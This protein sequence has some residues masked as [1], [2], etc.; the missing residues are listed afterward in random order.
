DGLAAVAH[1]GPQGAQVMHAGEEDGAEGDP[2]E[3]GQPA[4]DHRDRGA[5][6]RG[7]AGDGGEVV[8]PQDELVGGDVVDP[9]LQLM[10][11]GAEGGAE[12]VDAPAEEA[13]VE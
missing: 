1:R 5:H 4:P 10:G 3:G 6:D 13:A 9:I 11:G 12:P 2:E 8:A 7:G